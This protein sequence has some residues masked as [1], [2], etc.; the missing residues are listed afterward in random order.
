MPFY[1]SS[2]FLLLQNNVINKLRYWGFSRFFGD[3]TYIYARKR[4]RQ[5]N[6]YLR[7]IKFAGDAAAKAVGTPPVIILH[8]LYCSGANWYPTAKLIAGQIPAEVYTLDLPNHGRSEWCDRFSYSSVAEDVRGWLADHSGDFPGGVVLLGHSIGGRAAMVAAARDRIVKGLA[9]ADI[10]PF[11]EPRRDKIITIVHSMLLHRMAE[12]KQKGVPDAEIDDYLRR[13]GVDLSAIGSLRLSYRQMNLAL[14]ADKAMDLLP[15]WAG[16]HANED[17]SRL[18]NLPALFIRG[19][20]DSPYIP[21]FAVDQ[22]DTRFDNYTVVTM[23]GTT[24]NLYQEKP[25]E[26]A[27]IFAGWYSAN[28]SDKSS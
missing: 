28:F 25:G 21:R 20:E 2:Y 18:K 8:G 26:F 15:D 13:E 4:R 6:L 12:A 16:L 24:H 14:V 11:T 3:L 22:L 1:I 19:G 10:S 27:D 17:Y 7:R 5:M 9:M 23:E